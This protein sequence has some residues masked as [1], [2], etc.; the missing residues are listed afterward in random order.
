[1]IGVAFA[2]GLA[3]GAFCYTNRRHAR[4]DLKRLEYILIHANGVMPPATT[5]E[6]RYLNRIHSQVAAYVATP[7]LWVTRPPCVL[8]EDLPMDEQYLEFVRAK[9]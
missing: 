5:R 6:L 8:Y 3:W 1:M 7:Q 9:M 4:H 2:T